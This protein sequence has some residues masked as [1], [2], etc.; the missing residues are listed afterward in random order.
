MTDIGDDLRK[1]DAERMVQVRQINNGWLVEVRGGVAWSVLET[2]A[3]KDPE[4]VVEII[5]AL[6]KARVEVSRLP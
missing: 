1:W 6:M 4:G 5:A 2:Y 3:A